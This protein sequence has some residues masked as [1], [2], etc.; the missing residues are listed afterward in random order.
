MAADAA[1]VEQC[2]AKRLFTMSKNQL[3]RAIGDKQSADIV[4]NKLKSLQER[5]NAVM[6]KHALYQA[7]NHPDESDP[8]DEE[9]D[10]WMQ[11]IEND[12]DE[13]ER[14]CYDYMKSVNSDEVKYSEVQD[15]NPQA[16]V[17]ASRLYK[18]ETAT[19]E[20]M[21]KSLKITVDDESAS[22][23][24]I[25]DAQTE[26]KHQTSLYKATQRE[27]IILLDK[28]S[29]VQ[30]CT[31]EMQKLLEYCTKINVAA[32]K[33]I[34]KRT[35]KNDA[36]SKTKSKCL[37]LKMERMKMPKFDGD[38]REYPRFKSDFKKHVMPLVTTN[39]SAAYI[40]KSCLDKQPLETIKNVDDDLDEMWM[41]LDD[42]YG[43]SSKIVDAIMY[44]IK[45][46]KPVTENNATRFVEFVNTIERCHRDL[47]RI[48]MESEICNSTIVSLIEERLPG[49]IK[50]AWCL[51]VSEKDTQIDDTNKFPKILDFLLKHKRAIEY[52]SNDL[53][54]VK[55]VNFALH[56]SQTSSQEQS[57]SEKTPKTTHED[58]RC[59]CWLHSTSDHDIFDCR[60]FL[61]MTPQARIDRATDF[62]VCWCCLRTGHN[63]SRCFKLKECTHSDCKRKHHPML[64]Q[65]DEIKMMKHVNQ[66]ILSSKR[67]CLLQIMRLR[68]GKVH[69]GN[70]NVL[71]D[72][73]AQISLITIK[74]AKELG[75][76]GPKA[77]INIVKV[78]NIKET[79]DSKV[80]EVP[81]FDSNGELETFKAYGIPQI[82]SEIE[83]IETDELARQFN[84]NPSDFQRPVGEIDMLVGY[85]YAGFHPERVRSMQH[86]LLLKN[87]FG[88]CLGGA[89][90]LL[91]EKTRMLI[92]NVQISLAIVTIEDFYSN[93]SL[94][95]SCEPKCGSCKCGECPVGGKQ[96]TLKQERELALIEE[97]LALQ[98][99]KWTARYPW[100]RHPDELPNN[101][102]AAFAMLKSTER[103]LKK[104][105]SHME[106]YKQQIQDMLD[107]GV[108][109]K[110]RR[111]EL[112]FYEGPIY[113]LSHHE[114]MKPDSISTPCRIVFNASAKFGGHV[115]NDYW[116]KGP[117]LLN[118]LL[119]ILIRFREN[120]VAVAG[121]IRKM[122]HSVSISN[123]DQHT[124]RFLWRD[125]E[126]WKE[127]VVYKMTCV[128]FGDKP[129][130]AIA[131][132]ALRKTAEL[133]AKE[134]PIAA[135]TISKNAYVDDILG[136]FDNNDEADR[137]TKEIDIALAKGSF[138]IKNWTKSS[139]E[140]GP[141]LSVGYNQAD[142]E[143]ECS[144]VLGVVW[145]PRTDRLEFVTKLNFSTKHRNV[146]TE[147]DLCR[148]DIPDMIPAVMTKRMIL[149]QVNSVYDPLGLA[150][151]FVVQAKFLLRNL[152][153]ENKLD[154]D[155]AVPEGSREE[156]VR[157]FAN[158]FEMEDISFTRSTKPKDA[159]GE[160]VLVVFSDASERAF[161]ACAYIR[162]KIAGGS[163]KTNL[164]VAKSRLAPI[165]K[166]TIPRLELNAALLASRLNRFIT[167]ESAM[168]FARRYFIVDSEIVR[169]QIQKESYGFST[170]TGVRVGEIQAWTEKNDWYW[171]EGSKNISDIISRGCDPT[172]LGPDSVWQNGPPFLEANEEEW[173]LK[174]TFSGADLPDLLRSPGNHVMTVHVSDNK[175]ISKII[176][177]QHYSS[178]YKLLRVTSRVQAIF[179]KP[180]SLKNSSKIPSREQIKQAE[181]LW[182]HDAQRN[183]L[184][185]IKPETYKRLGVSQVNGIYVVGSRLESW[186]GHTYNDKQPIL[187]S[188]KSRLAQLY[189]QYVHDSCHLG[190]SATASKIRGK[191]WIIGLRQLLK[192]IKFRCTICKKSDGQF[193]Q[194]IMG[195]L[196]AERLNPAPA[197]SYVSIDLFGPYSIRGEANKRTRSR[198]YGVIFNCLLTRAVHLDVVCD[199]ST[200]SFLMALRRFISLRG[201]PVKMFSDR[202]TQLRA[203]DKELKEAAA[204]LDESV[205]TEFSC[206]N[207]FEW[208]FCSPDAPW[209]NGCS[210]GLIKS[211]KKALKITIGE[212]VL[213]YTEFQTVL[214]ECANLINERPIGRH[215]T[216]PEDGV[217]L[218]PNDLLLGRSS[219]KVPHQQFDISGSKYQRFKFVQKIT[220]AFW[221]RWTENYFPS[222]I[223]QQKW[224]ASK[225]NLKQ[226]DIVI[227]QD[228]NL[229]R[230]KWR[231]GRITKADA[232]L[233]DGFVR[234]VEVEYKNPGSDNYLSI[235]RAVQ[236]IIV[237][238][239]VEDQ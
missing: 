109:E 183:L 108:A 170:F 232:S 141:T 35:M 87:K 58:T 200:N 28:E 64:H 13:S 24:T 51:E 32:G 27:L 46:L 215:P 52:G 236:R 127:P 135:E 125:L 187:L 115:L 54:S 130:G 5:M 80:Y 97:G 229:I 150:A 73:G 219:S 145:N 4:Q 132:L 146:R 143:N 18:L 185:D 61:D 9:D 202:G 210:E 238:V 25:I 209:Q 212:Q 208:E 1:K 70:V 66:E 164:L 107:R 119:G 98:D 67:S 162:W 192:S 45:L 59:W 6:E 71:W 38:I 117:D 224:H 184:Q 48:N 227:V 142:S 216:S 7:I 55:T 116:A 188:S 8:S 53:R 16:L 57:E 33:E 172:E 10:T 173:P 169:A 199:Y 17:K 11:T 151:P 120:S 77:K 179:N 95:V 191:F 218:S 166:L 82:S 85:E 178:Y 41:R 79:I 157:F 153:K 123:L 228:S 134:F 43:R 12:F 149:S 189:A 198:G 94:G 131:A 231:L 106:L 76:S 190:I 29:E 92:Q 2:T 225:R 156:S 47:Q 233:R 100:I 148:R 195:K 167:K 90:E 193:Q 105:A 111:D 158:L 230:G 72:S 99:D 65:E 234:N 174:Q 23:Q 197:W 91:E 140:Y 137:I 211:V 93:E 89:H 83:S 124:H 180:A 133:S 20:S 60:T 160:P 15:T 223:I 161:G 86:L 214:L 171:V 3:T 14:A 88:Q 201:C 217:Y 122:Y 237:L 19:L 118:N 226:G 56:L 128:S 165:K 69:P 152:S 206:N 31:V 26:L 34:E 147:P 81:I 78:G 154:W 110:I 186:S 136:S 36:S 220:D 68:A 103:R 196:P 40:L 113:Y 163:F 213:T 30:E 177:I 205:L 21:T 203:A 176:D 22:S 181:E 114:V 239:P 50:S 39:D 104:N 62:R 112:Q 102:T 75:L 129:A 138:Q 182:I 126:E 37:D 207:A 168:S 204:G 139:N 235:T 101:Y 84:V 63:Q 121:D 175:Q 155:D 44:D 49:T 96:Y 222:L 144:K 194:Q 159:V 221:K 42:K 74:K